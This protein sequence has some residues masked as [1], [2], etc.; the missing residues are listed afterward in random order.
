MRDIDDLIGPELTVNLHHY[1]SVAGLYGVA[2]TRQLWASNAYYLNDSSEILGAIDFTK[3]VAMRI[4]E[5]SDGEQKELLNQL[6][7]WLSFLNSPQGIYVFSLS[8]QKN[9]LTQWRAYTPYG[10]GVTMSFSANQVKEIARHN[11]CRIIRCQYSNE[12]K[13]Q[14]ADRIVRK[15]IETWSN[16]NIDLTKAHPS[17]KYHPLFEELKGNYLTAFA[18]FKDQRFSS[19]NEWRLVPKHLP[20]LTEDKID[21]RLGASI[22]I[23][24]LKL[25]FPKKSPLFDQIWVG[26]TEHNNLSMHAI[27]A[28]MS[29][30]E[31][32]KSGCVSSGIPY[33]EWR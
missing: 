16:V 17:Q 11:E 1:T 31:L 13:K 4:S 15:T 28:F 25:E 5:E 27:A 22:L 14:L 23:P 29:K 9:D 21:Y 3:T 24:Y 10:K 8:E 20:S 19:E 7:N 30:Y 12:T 6:V 26:P 32:V 33:R 18:S 2:S